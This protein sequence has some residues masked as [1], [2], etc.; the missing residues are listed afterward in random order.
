MND[1]LDPFAR[2]VLEFWFGPDATSES[3]SEEKVDMW[4]ANGSNYD[5]LVRARFGDAITRAGAGAFDKW[6][7]SPRGRLALIVLT[8]QVPRHVHRGT[9]GAFATDAKAREVCL[10]GI[11]LGA[12]KA[13]TPIQRVVYYLPLEHAEDIAVQERC[14]SLYRQL[15]DDVSPDNLKD[16]ETNVTFAVAHRDIISRF[17]YFPH[18]NAIL[19][20][21]LSDAEHA[22]LQEPNSAF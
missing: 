18:R 19:G 15:L 3:V 13:L 21:P 6:C 1:D 14:V 7:E 9:P 12:D 10:A 11:K 5:D 17:G 8:D 20:R 2:E 16:Y 22:F 4:F